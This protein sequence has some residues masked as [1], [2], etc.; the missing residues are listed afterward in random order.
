MRIVIGSESFYPNVSGVSVTT[1]NLASYLAGRGHEVA[2]VAPSQHHGSYREEFANGFTVWRIGSV[3]NPFRKDFRVTVYPLRQVR[4]ALAAW[5]PDVIHLQDPTS[6][7]CVLSREAKARHIPV[8]ISHHFTLDYILTYLRLLK[9]FH[10]YL[11]RRITRA[12][13]NF[14]NSC[15]HVICPSETVKNDLLQAG[16]TTSL[17]AVSN[18]VNLNRFFAY[19]LPPSVRSASR[20]PDKPVVLYVGRLDPD[21][22]LETFLD[23]VPLVLARSKAHFVLCGGGNLLVSLKNLVKEKGLEEYVSFLGPF[24]YLSPDLPRVYQL[25]TC[26]VIPSAIESQSI[27]TLEAMASG[28]PVVA[29]SAGALPE[30]VAD[31]DN[32]FLFP[33]GDAVVLAEKVNRLLV[34]RDLCRRMGQRSLEKVIK[35]ELNGSLQKIEEIYYQVTGNAPV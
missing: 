4:A 9:P 5:L 35:H 28:L 33:P 23:A 20:L 19:E 2:V 34:D 16:L 8:V 24:G 25:A 15:A 32:G 11:R 13:I 6:I 27:V 10:S 31:G 18:G 21:K 1:F 3:S 12:M 29:P 26:F 17:T 22:G 14:Y 7:G 30:L